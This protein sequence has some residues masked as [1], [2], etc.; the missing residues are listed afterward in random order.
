MPVTFVGMLPSWEI[1]KRYRLPFP[2][3]WLFRGGLTLLFWDLQCL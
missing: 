1:C 3:S 2:T